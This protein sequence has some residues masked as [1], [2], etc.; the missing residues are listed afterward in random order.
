MTIV[1]GKKQKRISIFVANLGCPHDCAFCN[2][3]KITGKAKNYYPTILEVEKSIEDQIVTIDLSKSEVEIAFFG[4]SFTGL[5]RDYQAELLDLAS[6]YVGDYKLA[7]IRFSTRPDYINEEIIKFLSAY[8]IAS[9]ELGVQSFD[10]AVLDAAGR[11]HSVADVTRAIRLIKEA[12]YDLGIQLMAGLPHD[13]QES[14]LASVDQA[15]RLEADFLRIYPCLVLAGT[16][17]ADWYLAGSYQPWTLGETVKI[18]AMALA[19]LIEEDIPVIRIGLQ[20]SEDLQKPGN[21]L[22]G[23]HH[24][25]IRQMVEGDYFRHKLEEIINVKVSEKKYRKIEIVI[26]PADETAIR[27]LANEHLKSLE[28]K[29]NLAIIV[30]KDYNIP[31]YRIGGK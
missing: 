27:G 30:N 6:R 7:G 22:A 25:N 2:Q 21:V 13:R 5:P 14:F 4:G 20:E 9:I 29:Y 3:E 16:D 1:K 23:P 8:P 28:K 18:L 15:I 12:G 19:K 17:L 26:N 11:G 10:Q 24:P 31:R